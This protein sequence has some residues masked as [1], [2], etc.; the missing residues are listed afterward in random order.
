MPTPTATAPISTT[1]AALATPSPTGPAPTPLPSSADVHIVGRLTWVQIE[2]Y[3]EYLVDDAGNRWSIHWPPGV[4]VGLDGTERYL[5]NPDGSVLARDGDT[6]G[7]LGALGWFEP[8]EVNVT[9]NLGMV[10]PGLVAAD[11][12]KKRRAALRA[13]APLHGLVLSSNF[14]NGRYAAW[15]RFGI[16]DGRFVD[17]KIVELLALPEV[18]SAF[19]V[20]LGRL[21]TSWPDALLTAVQVEFVDV[22][23]ATSAP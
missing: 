10:E 1:I 17:A 20:G 12:L 5:M 23:H 8:A 13:W 7:V 3:C 2:G 4:D 6:V 22:A 16:T 14:G 15:W 19:R 11:S 21:C 9:L 18:Q